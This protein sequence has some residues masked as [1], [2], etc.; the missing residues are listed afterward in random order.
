MGQKDHGRAPAEKQGQQTAQVINIE[1]RP[2]NWLNATISTLSK[3]IGSVLFG[4]SKDGKRDISSIYGYQPSLEFANYYGMFAR[5]GLA[6]RIVASIPRSC[7]RDGVKVVEGESEIL[8]DQIAELESSGNLSQKLERADVLGRLGRFSVLFVG[9]PDGL[10]PEKPLGTARP[11]RLDEVYFAPYAEDGIEIAAWEND[12]A[13]PR[14]GMPTMYQ[15]SVQTRG[16]SGQA[17]MTQPRRVHWSRVVHIA[18]DLLD[19]DVEGM[20]VLQAVFN[21][22]EDLNKTTGG[23]AEA[24][25]RNARN[26]FALQTDPKFNA[27]I[28]TA[29]K[30]AL[31]EEA[32]RFQNDWQDFIRAGGIDVKP[33]TIPHNDPAGTVHVILQVI[34]GTTGIPIRILTG[35]GAGQLAG[36]EDKESYN[37]LIQDRKEVYCS[38]WAMRVLK[39]LAAAK[40]LDLPKKAKIL[41]STPETLSETDKATNANSKATALASIGTAL[42]TPAL[43]GVISVDQAVQLVFGEEAAVELKAT[44]EGDDGMSDLDDLDLSADFMAKLSATGGNG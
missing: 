8:A 32:Q 42:S 31:E 18:E 10:E 21:A 29:E 37:Q 6:K 35:E 40:M 16:D 4:V 25:F 30:Q 12:A 2:P 39:I 33:L 11:D 38:S 27:S 41:W 3:R 13:S 44:P 9:V 1:T 43:D 24:Y 5:G 14:Y 36:N 26:R 19:N 34:S 22:L 23:A 17:V 15:L 28:G 20:P 7:W